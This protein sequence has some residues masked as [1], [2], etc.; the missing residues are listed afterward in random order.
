MEFFNLLFRVNIKLYKNL[1]LCLGYNKD[2]VN[3][4]E[5]QESRKYNV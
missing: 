2:C 4:A 1:Q 5:R 3:E